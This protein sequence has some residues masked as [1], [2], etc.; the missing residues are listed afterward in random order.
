MRFK[1]TEIVFLTHEMQ[2]KKTLEALTH[3]FDAASPEETF[4]EEVFTLELL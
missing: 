3:L 4:D 2:K 1:F